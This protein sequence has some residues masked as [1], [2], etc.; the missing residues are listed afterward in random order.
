MKILIGCTP[1]GMAAF[2][3][4]GFEGCISDYKITEQ[5]GFLDFI[6]PGDKVFLFTCRLSCWFLESDLFL[7]TAL[8]VLKESYTWNVVAI[9]IQG[10]TY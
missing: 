6:E 7:Y 4:D 8:Y 9:R 10:K 3:S 1:Q 5:S 2:I